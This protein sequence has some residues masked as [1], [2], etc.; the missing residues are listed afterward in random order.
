MQSGGSRIIAAPAHPT[1]AVYIRC[2]AMYACIACDHMHRSQSHRHI[3]P[4]DRLCAD[5]FLFRLPAGPRAQASLSCE[6]KGGSVRFGSI[7]KEAW[8]VNARAD[9]VFH[10]GILPWRLVAHAVRCV[11]GQHWSLFSCG[12][13]NA[14]G[15]PE[16]PE[17][18]DAVRAPGSSRVLCICAAVRR[19]PPPHSS[20][21]ECPLP[22]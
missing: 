7:R 2:D 11:K 22:H 21:L 5:A 1:A 10:V 14:Q 4:R 13:E 12:R 9:R 15:L 18:P 6:S 20:R 17:L 3:V 16:L 8:R 19:T